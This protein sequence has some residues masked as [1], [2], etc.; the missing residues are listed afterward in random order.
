MAQLSGGC[1]KGWHYLSS[2]AGSG[3]E[4]PDIVAAG[5]GGVLPTF[6]VLMSDHDGL[7]AFKDYKLKFC[8]ERNFEIRFASIFIECVC[9]ILYSNSIVKH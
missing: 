7:Y 3:K 2:P 4:K 9:N 5:A 1:E 6:Y 8:K